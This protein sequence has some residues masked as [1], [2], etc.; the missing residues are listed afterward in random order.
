MRRLNV[1]HSF[2]GY[3]AGAAYAQAAVEV[4]QGRTPLRFMLPLRHIDPPSPTHPHARV[5]FPSFSSSSSRL[6]P[7]PAVHIVG[8]AMSTNEN[9][10]A[11]F[12]HDISPYDRGSRWKNAICELVV[13]GGGM[14]CARVCVR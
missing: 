8:L 3:A 1:G 2:N 4:F 12:G 6:P 10:K 11:R 9:I 14:E 7:K 5:S 13:Q